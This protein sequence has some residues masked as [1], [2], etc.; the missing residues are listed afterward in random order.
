MPQVDLTEEQIKRLVSSATTIPA[1]PAQSKAYVQT[2]KKLQYIDR[3]LFVCV[4]LCAVIMAFIDAEISDRLFEISKFVAAAMGI[5]TVGYLANSA[6]EKKATA[7]VEE[8]R[9][10]AIYQRGRD[11]QSS[12]DYQDGDL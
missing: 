10:T 8:S 12:Q 1:Q 3:G 2:S 5:G 11:Y 9:Y 7:R 4:I 6:V